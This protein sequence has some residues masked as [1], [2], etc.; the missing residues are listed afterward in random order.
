MIIHVEAACHH[1]AVQRAASPCSA[2]ICCLVETSSHVCPW[3]AFKRDY[4]VFAAAASGDGRGGGPAAS[5]LLCALLFKV[6]PPCAKE[7]DIG[8]GSGT[9]RGRPLVASPDA[10]P[11]S[12]PSASCV[13][14]RRRVRRH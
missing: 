7:E 12:S 4:F 6:L 5:P 13:V 14:Q 1:V 8:G 3:L 2:P 11:D 9:L 10:S